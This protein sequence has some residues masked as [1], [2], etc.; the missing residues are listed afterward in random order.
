MT[1]ETGSYSIFLLVRLRK[2]SALM[3]DFWLLCCFGV[4]GCP[5]AALQLLTALKM[6][7]QESR[8]TLVHLLR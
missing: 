5:A 3:K 7:K 6:Y 1:T 2:K 8:Q 4:E